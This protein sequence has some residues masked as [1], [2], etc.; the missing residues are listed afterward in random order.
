MDVFLSYKQT[1]VNI[2]KLESDL[3]LLKSKVESMNNSLFIYYFDIKD[4]ENKDIMQIVKEEIKKRELFICFVNHDKLSEWMLLEL[5]IAYSQNKRIILLVN[6]SV[7][8]SLFLS[9]QLTREVVYFDE[10]ED[11]DLNFI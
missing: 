4:E 8:D 5:W 11:I 1:W 3:W 10:I 7:K 2:D 6:R 9:Y